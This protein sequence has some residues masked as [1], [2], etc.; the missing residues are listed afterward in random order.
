MLELATREVFE[1]MLASQLTLADNGKP[2][3][4]IKRDCNGG[5]GGYAVR[6]DERTLCQGSGRSWRRRCSGVEIDNVG[7]DDLRC[8]GRDLQHGGGKLQ[9]QDFRAWG[10]LHALPP[11]VI[12]GD[13]YT[14][15]SQPE[16]PTMEV[17]MLFERCP[18]S[19]LC[20]FTSKE[21]LGGYGC[22]GAVVNPIFKSCLPKR[23]SDLDQLRRL[24]DPLALVFEA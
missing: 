7:P 11:S 17:S 23:S 2:S 18:W 10:R 19:F 22:R 15:H 3:T 9:E 14:V 13:D 1:T 20:I 16:T 12:T 8:A 21:Q 4:G 6:S 24:P 5:P